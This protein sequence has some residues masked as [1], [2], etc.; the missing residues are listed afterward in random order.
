MKKLF[1]EIEPVR[2]LKNQI[3]FFDAETQGGV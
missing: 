1:F 3:S 2:V